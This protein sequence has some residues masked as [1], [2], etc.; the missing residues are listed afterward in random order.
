[1]LRKKSF[2]ELSGKIMSQ[3]KILFYKNLKVHFRRKVAVFTELLAPILVCLLM[4][5]SKMLT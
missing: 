5:L 2:M 4:L 1:M 3:I